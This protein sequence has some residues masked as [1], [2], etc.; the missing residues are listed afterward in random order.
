MVPGV[1]KPLPPIHPQLQQCGQSSDLHGKPRRLQCSDQARAAFVQLN[2]SF[3]SAPILKH[4]DPSRPFIIEVD[5]SSCGIGAILCQRH[6]TP[7]KVYPCAFFSHKLIPA[8]S[9]Y[10]VGNR[11]LLSIKASLEEWRHWPEGACHPFLVLMDHRNLEYLRNAK[12]LNPHQ[13]RWAL[14]FTRFQF[15]VSY[16]PGSRNGKADA[17][18]RHHDSTSTPSSPE[19]IF[20]PSIVLMPIWWNLVEEIRRAQ[21]NE[22]PPL[23]C[24]PTKLYV[25]ALWHSRVLQWVHEAPSSGHPGI[26]RTTTLVQERFWWPSM[27]Q[28]VEDFVESCTTC[29]QVWTSRQLPMGLLEPLPVP[30]QSWSHMAVDFIT[31]LQDSKGFNTI[32]VEVG[33]FF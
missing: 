9:N 22:P 7:G 24:P 15:S 23:A 3:T 20:H 12:W 14:F 13:A 1:R 29:A 10:D 30:N 2:K 6:R 5:A 11:E 16:C 33:L 4:P 28:D 31:D 8:E 18:S 21:G 19:T 32:L 25:P 26:Q 27:S 17:L